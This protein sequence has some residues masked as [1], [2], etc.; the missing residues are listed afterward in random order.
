VD[1]SWGGLSV[2]TTMPGAIS[3]A[4]VLT[5]LLS[6][7]LPGR[8]MRTAAVAV[9]LALS[10]AA[11]LALAPWTAQSIGGACVAGLLGG[12]VV[13]QRYPAARE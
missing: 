2:L 8:W 9:T 4:Y 3:V 10:L 12:E 7:H 13:G 11:A 6:Q 5:E 1:Q